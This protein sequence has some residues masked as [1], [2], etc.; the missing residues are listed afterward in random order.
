MA[1]QAM[2]DIAAGLT[3]GV[4]TGLLTG[5]TTASVTSTVLTT[6]LAVATAFFGLAGS[7]KLAAGALNYARIISFALAMIVTLPASIW[8]RTHDA[9]SPTS[10]QLVSELQSLGF[11]ESQIQQVVMRMKYGLVAEGVKIPDKPSPMNSPLYADIPDFCSDFARRRNGTV[12]D[13]M[14]WLAT[15]GTHWQSL[16]QKVMHLPPERREKIGQAALFYV[17]GVE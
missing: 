5:L 1:R 4:L 8:V 11:E 13:Q 9:L 6:V 16:A 7:T 3:L 12:D 15:Q 2:A 17:C 10:G 14:A